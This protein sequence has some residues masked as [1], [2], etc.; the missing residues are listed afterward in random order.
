[1]RPLKMR[2]P[3]RPPN[4]AEAVAGAG[5]PSREIVVATSSENGQV[6]V[7]VRDSGAPVTHDVLARM[8]DPFFTTKQEGLGMGLPICRTII[9]AHG[10]RLWAEPNPEGGLTVQFSLPRS[11]AA[12]HSA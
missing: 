6:R 3:K 10:G 8:F 5:G 12:P 9:E 4:A 1:M 7:A 11:S 2:L